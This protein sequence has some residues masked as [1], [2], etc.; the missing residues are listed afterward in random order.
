LDT[1]GRVLPTFNCQRS[2]GKSTI[3]ASP[4]YRSA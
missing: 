2:T 1:S 4:A 3:G